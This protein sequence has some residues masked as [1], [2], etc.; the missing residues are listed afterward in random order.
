MQTGTSNGL[1]F[2]SLIFHREF[3]ISIRYTAISKNVVK[4][5][6]KSQNSRLQGNMGNFQTM[7]APY[8]RDLRWRV[9]WMKEVLGYEVN[10]EATSLS[11]SPRTV[12]RYRRQFLNF[13]N[14]NPEVIGRPLNS[15]SM[16]PY[17]E[18]LIMGA[19][20]KHPEKRLA[21]IA[22]EVYVQTGSQYTL[23]GV[24]C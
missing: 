17:V 10:E 22:H 24:F 19:V 1:L 2:V 15:V 9:I 8:S 23:A 3:N 16:H 21:E 4:R 14:I 13:G 12:E 11:L 20:L 7:P 6:A 5:K 18:F